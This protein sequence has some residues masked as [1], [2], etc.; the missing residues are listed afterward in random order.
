[1]RLG[2]GIR[3]GWGVSGSAAQWLSDQVNR[4]T[5]EIVLGTDNGELIFQHQIGYGHRRFELGDHKLNIGP[6]GII[7]QIA[8]FVFGP[9]HGG[10]NGV[11]Q[12]A[13]VANH[14]GMFN[15]CGHGPTALVA[16]H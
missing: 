2:F 5:L 6:Y 12:R 16:Q 1:M 11:D 8:R 14:L 13:D 7:Q 15:R 9:V 4:P 3:G 10:L